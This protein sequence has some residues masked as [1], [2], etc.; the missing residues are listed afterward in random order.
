MK[1]DQWVELNGMFSTGAIINIYIQT[2]NLLMVLD[3]IE[4]ALSNCFI[5]LGHSALIYKN[6]NK[7]KNI[8]RAAVHYHMPEIELGT[9]MMVTEFPKAQCVR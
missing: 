1:G 6:R 8:Y 3:I 9:F 2:R 4:S 5:P 7:D